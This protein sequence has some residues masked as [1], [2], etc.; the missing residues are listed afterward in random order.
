[1]STVVSIEHSENRMIEAI[2][3]LVL[4]NQTTIVSRNTKRSTSVVSK[5]EADFT[6]HNKQNTKNHFSVALP[7]NRFELLFWG[8]KGVVLSGH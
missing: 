8:Y 5:F 7:K 3:N 6:P 2:D 1:M 4:T